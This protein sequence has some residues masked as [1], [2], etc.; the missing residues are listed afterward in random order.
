[1]TEVLATIRLV[2]ACMSRM[3]TISGTCGFN[4]AMM[5][6]LG[7]KQYLYSTVWKVIIEPAF[8][9]TTPY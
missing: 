1:M 3:F 2:P 7:N 4:M 6:Q 9:A 8:V 5:Q